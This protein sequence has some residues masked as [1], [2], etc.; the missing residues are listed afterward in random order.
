MEAVHKLGKICWLIIISGT[1]HAGKYT[2]QRV[3]ETKSWDGS[4][5]YRL[6]FNK[7]RF[8][9]SVR[10]SGN[11]TFFSKLDVFNCRLRLNETIKGKTKYMSILVIIRRISMLYLK[12]IGQKVKP[13]SPFF[14]ISF[15]NVTF[16]T[17]HY[18]SPRKRPR[19]MKFSLYLV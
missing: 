9:L 13:P 14:W 10:V 17:W 6:R 2:T 4:Y 18:N 8:R 7:K 5:L 1:N 16:V 15:V 12:T 3:F 19:N 11:V